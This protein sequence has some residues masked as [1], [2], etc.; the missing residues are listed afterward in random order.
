MTTQELTNT[1]LVNRRLALNA[2]VAAIENELGTLAEHDT[3]RREVE[4]AM[5]EL[6]ATAR[7][8]LYVPILAQRVARDRLYA[9]MNQHSEAT[10]GRAG[11]LQG[12]SLG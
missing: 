2:A 11:S 7:I 3:V 1:F 8:H 4:R 12:T 5:E 9:Q 10:V 6:D